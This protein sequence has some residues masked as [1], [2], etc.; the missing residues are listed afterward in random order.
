MAHFYVIRRILLVG[1]P[2]IQFVELRPEKPG[3]RSEGAISQSPADVADAS[4][5][6][7]S[8]TL[9]KVA[10]KSAKCGAPVA[11]VH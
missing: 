10:P 9:A 6:A 3:P 5:R 1:A 2:T 11:T 8:G 4:E 7:A